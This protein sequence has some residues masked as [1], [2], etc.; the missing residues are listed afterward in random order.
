MATRAAATAAKAIYAEPMFIPKG[1][2]NAGR[3]NLIREI[4]IGFTLGLTGGI[5]WKVRV[6]ARDEAFGLYSAGQHR[7]SSAGCPTTGTRVAAAAAG[8]RRCGWAHPPP[9]LLP[10]PRQ[11]SQAATGDASHPSVLLQ[12]WH[13]GEKRRL[14]QYYSELYA[15]EKAEED[16]YTD[17][18]RAKLRALEEELLA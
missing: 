6:G 17:E 8:V 9:V 4:A 13:W 5:M 18:L 10:G 16:A 14:A 3:F 11:R 7:L 2:I 12:M 1:P 15:R